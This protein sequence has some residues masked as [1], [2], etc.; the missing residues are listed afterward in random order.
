[1]AAFPSL[2]VPALGLTAAL[3][4]LPL[5]GSF[6]DAQAQV[7]F[8]GPE[9]QVNTYTTHDQFGPSLIASGPSTFVVAWQSGG[10][11][12]TDTWSTSIQAQLYRSDGAP[13]GEQFQVNSYT[14]G[15][16]VRP[17][18]A[19]DSE[20][21]F[22]LVWYGSGSGGSD[23]GSDSI[24]ARRF[25]A[26]GTPIGA[27][28]QVNTYTTSF[29]VMPAVAVDPSGG[30][31][32]V[33]MSDGSGGSDTDGFSI[34]AQRFDATG[35]PVGG[36]SQVNSHTT[37]DQYFPSVAINAS[38]N[39]L[40]AWHST[41]SKGS[42]TSGWSIQAQIFGPDGEAVG[43]QFQ[44]NT[45]TTDSQKYPDV[46]ASQGGF[47]VVWESFGS[48]G[49]DTDGTSIQGQRF[50]VDGTPHG[51][52]FQVNTYTTSYQDYAVVAAQPEGGFVV[53]WKSSGSPGT[54]TSSTSV[55]AQRYAADGSAL[56][57]QFQVNTHTTNEQTYP[58][59][60]MDR[61]G[62][63]IVA[64]HSLGSAGTDH[65]GWSIQAQRF[66]ELF[67]DGFESGDSARWSVAVP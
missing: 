48:S 10:S 43:G 5:A 37:G 33:W 49:T 55:Q 52:Q 62:D 34:Q 4:L 46:A 41:S 63:F 36:E 54:D 14:P 61:S 18:A 17:A 16:Q 2:R 25:D 15:Y 13:L 9:F 20:G 67:R 38:G 39:C 35:S 31:V 53:A 29:Q 64:W 22:V 32:V 44:V 58:A 21:R 57:P 24:Q 47:V 59:V 66:D 56:G 23:T 19:G 51:S 12:G 65:D 8:N 3:G 30:F 26:A 50:T 28:F 27:D 1:M 6:E 60:A 7:S 45:Y 11:S 40:V 42:D